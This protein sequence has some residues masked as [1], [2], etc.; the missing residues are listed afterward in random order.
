MDTS[1]HHIQLKV[2]LLISAQ[3]K[4]LCTVTS[5]NVIGDIHNTYTDVHD[6]IFNSNNKLW[7][8]VMTFLLVVKPGPRGNPGATKNETP[9]LLQAPPA[10]KRF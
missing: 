9:L 7:I 2:N 3:V 6:C 1:I 4:V 10:V 8:S 5:K